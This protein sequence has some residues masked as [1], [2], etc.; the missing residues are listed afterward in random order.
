M[1]F[2]PAPSESLAS[3]SKASSALSYLGLPD[4]YSP[5]PEEQPLDFLTKHFCELP[6]HLLSHF[7]A[8]TT[9]K[10]RSAIPA[11]RNRRHAYVDSN[12]LELSFASAKA[13][14]PILW[15]GREPPGREQGEDEREWAEQLFM[16]SSLK[17]H[18]GKLGMLLAGY[19][20]E[21]SA[22]HVRAQRRAAMDELDRVPEEEESD[23]DD[24]EEEEGKEEEREESQPPVEEESI[25]NTKAWFLRRVRER[26]IYGLL[27]VRPASIPLWKSGLSTVFPS[28]SIMTRSTGTSRG[29]QTTTVRQKKLGLRKKKNAW[30]RRQIWPRSSSVLLLLYQTYRGDL[31]E[32][33]LSMGLVTLREH[34]SRQG[35]TA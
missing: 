1:A 7:S 14:W 15:P 2:A 33:R 12:P 8:N 18:I 26:F 23:D 27:E 10:Q 9:P 20:A 21:R 11:I 19:E 5:S 4:D 29:I 30:R 16:G 28:Q 25:E 6:P 3:T 24:E 13:S 34:D 17:P 32:H 35:Y 22:E 31:V